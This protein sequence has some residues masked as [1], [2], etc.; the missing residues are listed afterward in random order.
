MSLYPLTHGRYDQPPTRVLGHCLD[1][2][3]L[4]FDPPSV[5][6]GF[7]ASVG[8]MAVTRVTVHGHVS[9]I[10]EEAY[11]S[12]KLVIWKKKNETLKAFSWY[13]MS[14]VCK[15][16]MTQ[17]KALLWEQLSVH[18]WDICYQVSACCLVEYVPQE[19]QLPSA[20]GWCKKKMPWSNLGLSVQVVVFVQSLKET[21]NFCPFPH[22]FIFLAA[23]RPV[24]MWRWSPVC[25]HTK[26][27]LFTCNH[28]MLITCHHVARWETRQNPVSTAESGD[29]IL[30]HHATHLYI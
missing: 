9:W 20:S 18:S 17:S 7:I 1:L 12:R 8:K 2:S 19:M 26:V 25:A 5:S 10:T 21:F 15:L 27:S 6:F 29:I 11:W 3:Q 13:S 4:K 16:Y 22:R 14:I 30:H 23:W 28:Q 24:T